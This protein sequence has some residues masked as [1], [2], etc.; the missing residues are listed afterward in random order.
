MQSKNYVVGIKNQDD[1]FT[2]LRDDWEKIE[3]D[4]NVAGPVSRVYF[5]NT[6]VLLKV[7]TDRRQ[8]LLKAL[9]A[10]GPLTVKALA[11][12]LHRDY[13][14]VHEDVKILENAGLIVRESKH[15]ITAP[16]CRVSIELNLAA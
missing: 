16:Y 13:K 2:E 9:H 15:L 12:S 1:F 4:E 10:A 5:E 6:K 11:D 3:R 7:L 14:N 8:E